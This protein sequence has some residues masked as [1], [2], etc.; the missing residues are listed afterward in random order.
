MSATSQSSPEP[1]RAIAYLQRY[2]NSSC[3]GWWS[4]NGTLAPASQ[5]QTT[6]LVWSAT[7]DE[8][9]LLSVEENWYALVTVFNTKPVIKSASA[10]DYRASACADSVAGVNYR[11]IGTSNCL[12]LATPTGEW[13]NSAA[14]PQK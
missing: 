7:V 10:F 4:N 13:W 12:Q 9:A 6:S 14:G 8:C 5:N 11:Q 3:T 1:V 2:D